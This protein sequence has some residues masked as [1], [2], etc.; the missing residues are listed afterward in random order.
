LSLPH[1]LAHAKLCFAIYENWEQLEYV[2][3]NKTSIIKPQSHGDGR[4]IIMDYEA[5]VPK[6]IRLLKQSFGARFRVHADISNCFPSVYSHALPWALVGFDDAKKNKSANEWFNKIDKSLRLTKRN[7][8]QGIAIGPATSNVISEI[9]LARVDEKLSEKFNFVRFIDDY[10][11]DCASEQEAQDFLRQL[12]QELSIYKLMLN[13]KKTK[14]RR[15][16]A[17]QSE[18]W[19]LELST[20]IPHGKEVNSYEAIQFL[21]YAVGLSNRYPEGSVLKF[22][23][24]AILNKELTFMAKFDV[25]RFGITLSFY[26]PVLLP[27]LET[28]IDETWILSGID[29]IQKINCIVEEN[30]KLF[31]SDG[32]CWGLYLLSKFDGKIEESVASKVIATGDVF[33]I[34]MLYWSGQYMELVKEFADSLDKDDLYTLDNYWLLLYQLYFDGNIKALYDDDVFKVLKS[35]NVSFYIPPQVLPSGLYE[36]EKLLDEGTT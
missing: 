7:E 14:I 5:V 32:M 9:I 13:V 6:S 11:C 3:S 22:A 34:L 12:S 19:V 16:P 33:S 21:D 24:K 30:T 23:F 29:S 2:T 15:L 18:E 4:V 36:F 1:P 8:T 35:N 28:L 26:N 31:R 10:T 20:K 17:S 25:L 27:L